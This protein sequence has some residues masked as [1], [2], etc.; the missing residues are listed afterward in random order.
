MWHTFPCNSHPLSEYF[1]DVLSTLSLDVLWISL[2]L[3]HNYWHIIPFKYPLDKWNCLLSI[4]KLIIWIRLSK[5]VFNACSSRLAPRNLTYP[6]NSC[7]CDL[8]SRW[9]VS[10][11]I[12]GAWPGHLLPCGKEPERRDLQRPAR[13]SRNSPAQGTNWTKF[14]TSE[15]FVTIHLVSEYA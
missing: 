15:A 9:M 3:L 6:V 11:W 12:P 14:R 4:K 5:P 10:P 2:N 13:K 1:Y 7:V 8:D